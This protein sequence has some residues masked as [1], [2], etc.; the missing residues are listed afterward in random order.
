MNAQEARSKAKARN[1][2]E[3]QGDMAKVRRAIESAADE[4]KYGITLSFWIHS[5]AVSALENEGFKV[6][7]RSDQRDG[8]WLEI[9]W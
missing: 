6:N 5:D 4:G 9:T 1:T 2:N 7:Q 3:A 8:D